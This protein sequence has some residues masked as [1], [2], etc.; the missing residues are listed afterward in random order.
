VTIH[1]SI[2]PPCSSAAR[3]HA[4]VGTHTVQN[5]SIYATKKNTKEKVSMNLT[6]LTS[7][8][9]TLVTLSAC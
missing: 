3:K 9:I 7:M 1:A 2:H 5:K 8:S 6:L 4:R